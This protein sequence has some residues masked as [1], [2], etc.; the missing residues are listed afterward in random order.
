MK[1]L[2]VTHCCALWFSVCAF[3]QEVPSRQFL[4]YENMVK[5]SMTAEFRA[6]S[7]RITDAC[8]LHKVNVN[9]FSIIYDDN[10]FLN[11]FPLKNLADLDKNLFAE[12]ETK[13]GR[14]AFSKLWPDFF[15]CLESVNSFIT[16]KLEELSYLRPAEGEN[17]RSFLFITPILGKSQEI[18]KVFAEWKT[19][20]ESKKATE[21]FHV[22]RTRFGADTGYFIALWAKD[23]TEMAAKRSQSSKLLGEE[24]SRL[25]QKQ[26]A[27]IKK[28]YWKNG[29]M[30]PELGY[31]FSPSN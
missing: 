28:Y 25:W 2:I 3:A 6:S 10:T 16:T 15:K 20:Y 18:E 14:E 30:A 12:L 21:G 13:M 9:W 1:K 19:A 5:P 4:V 26:S 23:P 24:A 17:Y 31:S 7:K 11:I 29:Y 22:Y 27:F 8:T